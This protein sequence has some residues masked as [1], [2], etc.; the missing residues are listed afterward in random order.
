MA[1]K[2]NTLIVLARKYNDIY[3]SI[4]TEEWQSHKRHVL[5]IMP[6]R[7]DACSYPCQ[8]MFDE[9][10]VLPADKSISIIDR[11]FYIFT[12]KKYLKG[13]K[14]DLIV[15]SNP[16]MFINRIIYKFT[17]CN[18][19]IFVEDGLMNYYN[20][21]AGNGLIKKF[22]SFCYGVSNNCYLPKI[23]KTYV[24]YPEKSKYFFGK[25]VKLNLSDI[26]T[27]PFL[28]ITHINI[29]NLNG[30][31]ILIAQD[32]V[33]PGDENIYKHAGFFNSI[34]KEFKI[35]YYVPRCAHFKEKISGCEIL[36]I[37]DTGLTLELLAG[38]YNFEVYGFSTS[39]LFTL[40]AINPQI[41]SHRIVSSKC[42]E[43]LIPQILID[44]TD[45]LESFE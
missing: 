12:L 15:M 25:T 43:L 6:N 37:N 35:D 17:Q 42:Y 36:N 30:K 32:V 2:Q 10:I 44:N 16:E 45:I 40:K 26:V 28:N 38:K 23:I 21:K 7:A 8:S 13:V 34:I 14:G 5:L 29:P 11:L 31:R 9:V 27:D 4:C 22:L 39:L 33:E 1:D 41:K 19:I 3:Y 18:G 24:N 20:Y